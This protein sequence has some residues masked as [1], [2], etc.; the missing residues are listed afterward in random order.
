[1]NR[2]PG[3]TEKPIYPA[4]V[5]A[6]LV[7]VL[8][9]DGIPHSE[10]LANSGI[11]PQTLF[12]AST[13]LSQHQMTVVFRNAIRLSQDPCLALRAGARMH[14]AACGIYGYA[15]LSSPTHADAAAFAAK[16]DGVLGQIA[17]TRFS[18]QGE[19]ATWYLEPALDLDPLD[20]LYRFLLEFKTS[21]TLTVMKDL[22]GPDFRFS[23]MTAIYPEPIHNAA[24]LAR[25]ECEVRFGQPM[26][27]LG[28]DAARMSQR[29]PYADP[30]T[31]ATVRELCDQTLSKLEHGKGLTSNVHARLIERP[32]R[33][34]DISSM[35]GEM[36]M[37]ARTLRRKLEAEGSSYR[38]ILASVRT[39]LAANYLRTTDLT[40]EE[41]ASRLGFSDSASFRKAFSGWT[42]LSPSEYRR[43]AG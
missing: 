14:I 29:M 24:Y 37:N 35:A 25:F 2:P 26:N 15:L 22:Y 33:F 32:G 43:Q 27:E 11:D 40:T 1:M 18:T 19:H 42:R 12:S 36:G 16:Y 31:N 6:V 9:D 41:I 17:R 39:D 7:G 30:I 38:Q 13:R 20:P 3:Q 28:F 23:R 5:V 4:H 21:G 10:S 34:P 8:A